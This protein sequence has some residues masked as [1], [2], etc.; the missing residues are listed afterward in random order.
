MRILWACRDNPIIII[1]ELEL[2]LRSMMGTIY[3]NQAKGCSGSPR[4]ARSNLAFDSLRG[5]TRGIQKLDDF[6]LECFFDEAY[7]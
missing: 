3:A 1:T 4:D 2:F 6:R 5:A 7:L